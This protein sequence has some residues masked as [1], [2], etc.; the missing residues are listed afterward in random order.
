MVKNMKN[1]ILYAT[2]SILLV[3][4]LITGCTSG[5]N[6]KVPSTEE[7]LYPNTTENNLDSSDYKK[8]SENEKY[9]LLFNEDTTHFKVINKAYGTEYSSLPVE[10]VSGSTD[11]NSLLRIS[12]L[13]EKGVVSYQTSYEDSVS[14]GQYKVESIE[15]G[16]KVLYT[17]GT[18]N[19]KLYCPAS[20]T[21]ER[22]NKILNSIDGSFE[23]LKFKSMYY[24]ADI[25]KIA[26]SARRSELLDKYPKLKNEVLYLIKNTS[27]SISEQRTIND[28]LVSIGY[29]DDDYEK[30]TKGVSQI[31]EV[32]YPTFNIPL[33]IVLNDNGL[34]LKI[35]VKE[36]SE[37]NKGTLLTIDLLKYFNVPEIQEK[38]YFLLPD[39]SGSI[40]NFYNGKNDLQ[41]YSAAVYGRDY[42]IKVDEKINYQ[43]DAYLP[44][45]ANVQSTGSVFCYISDG[46]SLAQI[47]ASPGDSETYAVAYP[48]FNFRQVSQTYLSSSSKE[49]GDVFYV[50]QKKLSE[51]NLQLTMAFFDSQ[52]STTRNFADYY[53]NVVF[54]NGNN[55]A[56]SPMLLEF[57]G[58]DY[59]NSSFMGIST[60]KETVYT[61]INQVLEIAKDLK[62]KG[63]NNIAL[64]LSG[65]FNNGLSQSFAANLKLNK[66]VGTKEDLNNLLKWAKENKCSVYFDV[67]IQYVYETS[68]FGFS[69]GANVVQLISNET[70]IDYKYNPVT[71]Q[72]DETAESRYI[73]NPSAISKAVDGVLKISD[74]LKI[75][76]FSLSY[77]GSNVNSD[78]RESAPIER[79]EALDKLVSDVKRVSEKSEIITKGANAAV[80][81]YVS[82]VTDIPMKSMQYDVCDSTIPFLQMV[83]KGNVYYC[84]EARNIS[85][86]TKTGVLD[87]IR[88]GAG[89]NYVI[90]ANDDLTFTKTAHS[91]YTSTSYK[92]WKDKIIKTYNQVNSLEKHTSTGIVE[93][94]YLGQQV[95]ETVFGDSTKIITNYSSETQTYDSYEIKPCEYLVLKGEN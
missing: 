66:G 7:I 39:G 9:E 93:C 44:I 67:D 65:F 2:V 17:M 88:T 76:G 32:K 81:P 27:L 12:Y 21:V 37:Y 34:E 56:S 6:V 3:V 23:R 60:K 8:I 31:D 78:F 11:W 54:G 40:M 80:L 75:N 58:V 62:E 47:K 18:V 94:N 10:K 64:K 38:G 35:P 72:L 73:L 87:T 79:E 25:E 53:R 51:G 91:D 5:A 24:E 29:N 49:Q 16:V 57:I 61:T 77:I 55:S 59:I 36:V 20:F 74:K 42:S 50:T 4:F 26:D 70:G 82:Y 1:R 69:K 89:L 46:E 84:D 90:T 43:D 14:K 28:I 33:Y 45:Y 15:N 86:D 41:E 63:V 19:E 71:F 30:D 95:Y 52:N 48:S 13:N 85:G 83:L 22:Y 92:V 68:L